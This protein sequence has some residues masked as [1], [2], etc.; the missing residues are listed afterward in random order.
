M[1]N[2]FILFNMLSLEQFL[3]CYS[4]H[5]MHSRGGDMAAQ[6][7][8]TEKK[9]LSQKVHDAMKPLTSAMISMDV[10]CRWLFNK[11]I[12]GSIELCELLM[13]I[14][15]FPAFCH[16]QNQGTHLNVD[17]FLSR[18]SK[19]CQD[20][21]GVFTWS[22]ASFYLSLLFYRMVKNAFKLYDRM[23]A[24]ELLNIPLWPITAFGAFFIGFLTLLV[25]VDAW[26]AFQKASHAGNAFFPIFSFCAAIVV[27]LMPF[28]LAGTCL[29]LPKAAIGGVAFAYLLLLSMFGMPIGMS[30][31][32]SGIQGLIIIMPNI[33]LP[34]SMI[35]PSPV[36]SVG[37]ILMVV[38]PMF[39]LMGEIALFGD[40]SSDLFRAC[41]AWLG[42]LPG[43]L[44]I[45]TVGGCAGFAAVC[46][47]SVATAMT[48]AS[49]SMPAMR[50][51]KYNTGFAASC[52]AIGGPLGILIPP[53]LGFLVYAI[54]TEESVG[55]LFMAGVIPGILLTVLLAMTIYLRTLLNP[56][57][58]PRGNKHSWS[59]RFRSLTGVLPMLGLFS[60]IMG[61][62]LTGICTPNE[63]GA[64]ASFACLLYTIVRKK[65]NG[66]NLRHAV[67]STMTM[68]S[69]IFLIIIG[70]HILGYC[71]AASRFPTALS[72]F[73]ADAHMGKIGILISVIIMYLV[74]GCVMNAIPMVMLT[75]PAI[76]PSVL[77][78]GIDPIWFGVMTVLL[79]ELGQVTP[80]VGILVFAMSSVVP[81]IPIASIFY[82][83]MPFFFTILLLIVL[84]TIFPEIV[85]FLPSMLFS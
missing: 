25:L 41:S 51:K 57:L 74:L 46:G 44:A 47:D 65:M 2:I 81:D 26:V 8:L 70:V 15:C 30:M 59:E 14:A 34:L 77:S 62:M 45:A 19:K 18:L 22:V 35:G 27:S 13:I 16:T 3:H 5:C 56:S 72:T 67:E 79:M 50:E 71:L 37:A 68:T 28:W 63:G 64:L 11:P 84:I 76:F 82:H 10:L 24:T 60:I 32:V 7:K 58:A 1:I 4:I 38:I 21:C 48:M 20:I 39:I 75:M 69:K 33:N 83:I 80:P 85:L 31:L 6:Q 73:I 49:V 66:K 43:G 9:Y 52:L 55:K 12:F 54:I 61:G 53:S 42:H 17:I 78:V 40:V 29:G 36:H 23:E